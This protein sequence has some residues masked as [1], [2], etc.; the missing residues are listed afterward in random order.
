MEQEEPNMALAVGCPNS[1]FTRTT[2]WFLTGCAGSVIIKYKLQTTN[3]QQIMEV[4]N[5]KLQ[6]SRSKF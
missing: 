5:G 4:E 2:E 6:K 1:N 3:Q